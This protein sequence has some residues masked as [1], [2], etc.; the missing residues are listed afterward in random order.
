MD[1][2]KKIKQ[3]WKS[4][5]VFHIANKKKSEGVSVDW[6]GLGNAHFA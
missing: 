1:Y 3:N 2:G 6:L 5:N 4:A